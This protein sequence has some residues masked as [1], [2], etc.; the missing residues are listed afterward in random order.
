MLPVEKSVGKL[1]NAL[2]SHP[3][4]AFVGSIK[5]S[6][7]AQNTSSTF[8]DGIKGYLNGFRLFLKQENMHYLK[9]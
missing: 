2:G 8:N 9:K 3:V 4:V 7:T 1:T 5:S 6:I